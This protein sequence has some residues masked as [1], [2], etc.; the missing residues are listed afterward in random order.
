M[1]LINTLFT[2]CHCVTKMG[3]VFGLFR[4][5]W[6]LDWECVSKPVKCFYPRMVKG[7]VC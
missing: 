7:G 1:G 6:H 5:F 2:L 3:S 4:L